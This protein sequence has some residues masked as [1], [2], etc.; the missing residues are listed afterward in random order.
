MPVAAV[1]LALPID[2]G[3]LARFFMKMNDV[4]ENEPPV[5]QPNDALQRTR[6]ALDRLLRPSPLNAVLDRHF[7]ERATL[8]II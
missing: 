8:A 4:H 3:V 6:S 7:W 2:L 1:V 5:R